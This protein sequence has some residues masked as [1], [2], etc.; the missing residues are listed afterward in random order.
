MITESQFNSLFEK[1]LQTHVSQVSI[2]NVNISYLHLENWWLEVNNKGYSDVG[3]YI[4]GILGFNSI[5]YVPTLV[6]RY[7]RKRIFAKFIKK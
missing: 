5:F 3:R 7:Y 4:M 1:S 6:I 2:E